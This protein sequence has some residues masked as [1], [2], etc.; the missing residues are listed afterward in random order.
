[1]A[2]LKLSAGFGGVSTTDQPSYGTPTSYSS[3]TQAAF[4]PGVTVQTAS[5]AQTLAPN[6]PIGL[7]FTTGVIA[8][9]LLVV[10]R[11]SLP[12]K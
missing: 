2:G 9:A 4:G 1:M 8:V 12:G 11:H 7:A 6:D 5:A 10:I 3:V